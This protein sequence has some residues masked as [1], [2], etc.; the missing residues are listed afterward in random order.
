MEYLNS[1]YC[2][3]TQLCWQIGIK[4]PMVCYIGFRRLFLI[5][6]LRTWPNFIRLR[7]YKQV[8]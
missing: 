2:P 5:N 1:L 8:I 7:T 6:N 4:D 3:V